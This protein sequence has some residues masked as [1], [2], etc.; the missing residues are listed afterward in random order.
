MPTEK[1]TNQDAGSSINNLYGH[2]LLEPEG[3]KMLKEKCSFCQADSGQLKKCTRCTLVHYCNQTCQA[4]DF[5]RHKDMCERISQFL[6]AR[7]R[8][9]QILQPMM[10]SFP[11]GVSFFIASIPDTIR[12]RILGQRSPVLVQVTEISMEIWTKSLTFTV[13]DVTNY[14]ATIFFRLED[15]DQQQALRYRL[16]KDAFMLIL[17]AA[18]VMTS[19]KTCQVTISDLRQV[20]FLGLNT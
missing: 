17:K 5:G 1:P 6:T 4:S 13:R 11:G 14:T 8:V 7:Q 3:L 16:L 10:F 9:S 2:P 20:M 12:A 19:D 15:R 18:M